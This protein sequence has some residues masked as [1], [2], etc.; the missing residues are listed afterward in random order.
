MMITL[1]TDTIDGS[2]TGGLALTRR[3]PLQPLEPLLQ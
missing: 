2:V 1:S 3:K